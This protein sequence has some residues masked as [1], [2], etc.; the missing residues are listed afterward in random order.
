[1]KKKYYLIIII[2]SC[3]AFLLVKI[4]TWST[5]N[6]NIW[7]RVNNLLEK[8]NESKP[9]NPIKGGNKFDM[10]IDYKKNI[11]SFKNEIRRGEEGVMRYNT[12]LLKDSTLPVACQQVINDFIDSSLIRVNSLDS[13]NNKVNELEKEVLRCLYN[14]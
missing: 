1:M 3:I 8:T 7:N 9:G 5:S 13:L 2:T 14:N 4:Y 6:H 10:A 12:E 11:R